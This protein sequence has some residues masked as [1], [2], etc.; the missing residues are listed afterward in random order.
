M[1]KFSVYFRA[2]NPGSAHDFDGHPGHNLPPPPPPPPHD[3]FLDPP[4]TILRKSG[5]L[6]LLN[7]I[8]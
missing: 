2:R 8:D 3:K 1:G 4:L 5:P 7:N 6:S